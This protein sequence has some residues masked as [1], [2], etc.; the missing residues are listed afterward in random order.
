MSH[1]PPKSGLGRSAV[2]FAAVAF[3]ALAVDCGNGSEPVWSE[4]IAPLV[5]ARCASCHRTDGA[6]FSLETYDAARVNG[7]MM[8]HVTSE[9][10]MPPWPPGG[11]EDCPRLEGDRDLP[12]GDIDRI[13]AWVHAGMPEG[14]PSVRVPPSGTFGT[15]SGV[16]VV[17]GPDQPYTPS[18]TTDDYRCFPLDPQLASDAFITAYRVDAG[19]GVH[20]VILWEIDDDNAAL[21]VMA[22][23]AASPEPGL[24]CDAW[25]GSAN[26][27]FLTVWG[28]SD[29]VRRHP[30]GTGMR[31]RA[32]KKL[33][34]QVHYHRG[35]PAD[36][37][38]IGL[39]LADHVA[40][41]AT[42]LAL[43]AQGF[44]L[45]PHAAATSL[46]AELSLPSDVRLWGVR[47]HMHGLGSVA[48][49]GWRPP[50]SG[51]GDPR[52]LIDIPQWNAN[53][54]LMYFYPQA[55]SLHAGDL[56][57]LDCTFDTRSVDHQVKEGSTSNDEMC[58]G[59]LYVT[60]IPTP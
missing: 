32:G 54:Q 22:L 12:Q 33:Y 51:A 50:A 28:P 38:S 14:R 8:A 16:S 55:I 9:R 23:D 18:T 59:Y 45:E 20:H 19:P 10:I 36:R 49:I 34:S 31:V 27:R 48:H 43:A 1:A 42:I 5:G 29:P 25:P 13:G 60:G 37:T 39:A 11:G 46:H 17:L 56:V 24:A 58:W 30:A 6:A 3:S 57:N 44:V 21:D 7:G 52:C 2:C 40:E 47:P 35:S 15:L 4:D 41:E 53:W 26:M